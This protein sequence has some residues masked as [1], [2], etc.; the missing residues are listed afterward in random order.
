MLRAYRYRLYPGTEQAKTLAEILRLS[1]QVYNLALAHR[2]KRWNESR[3]LVSY[4]QQ[5]ALWRDWRNEDPEANPL[6]LM[7]TLAPR[8]GRV[9]VSAG[10]QVLRRLD[11]AYR[12]FLKGERGRPRFQKSRDFNSVNYKPGDGARLKGNR[13]YVQNVGLV[14]V[15]WHRERPD[16]VLKNIVIVRKPSGWYALLQYELPDFDVAP[17]ANPPVAAD[18]GIRHALALSDGTMVDS[19]RYL[20]K[21][22]RRL[23]VLQR[24]VARKTKG[25]SNRRKA[26]AKLARQHE[27]IDNQRRDFWHKTTRRLVDTYGAIALENLPLGFMLRNHSL[28]LAA[29]DVGLGIF[30]E[31]L[32]YKAIKAG[33]EIAEVNH[34]N[35]SQACSG[36]GCIVQKALSVRVHDCPNCGLVIDR[37]TNAALNIL[38]LGHSRWALTWPTTACVAQE[39]PP[40]PALAPLVGQV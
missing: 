11:S 19:P 34:H 2:R 6:R 7:N 30:R 27:R 23:R 4:N 39:A 13:L 40:L 31:L 12:M 22:L 25:G 9:R 17:S 14:R 38:R 10:Q 5:A 32:N 3:E 1:C 26:I 24:S 37:D 21:S 33:V 15:R 8:A 20:D 18:M 35:T 16:G 28:A 36:C 29:H